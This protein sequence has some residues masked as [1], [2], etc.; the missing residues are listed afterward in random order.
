MDVLEQVNKV[1]NDLEK[2]EGT[3]CQERRLTEGLILTELI[4]RYN[5]HVAA[6]QWHSANDCLHSILRLTTDMLAE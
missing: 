4:T 3:N 5:R 1:L 6:R 2:R